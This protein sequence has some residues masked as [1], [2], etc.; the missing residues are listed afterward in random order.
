MAGG[1]LGVSWLVSTVVCAHL[2]RKYAKQADTQ[3][4]LAFD[5]DPLEYA[6]CLYRAHT[7][8]QR[9][10][11]QQY[12]I[13]R[14][15]HEYVRIKLNGLGAYGMKPKVIEYLGQHLQE[16]RRARRRMQ[17]S[18]PLYNL[19]SKT[20]SFEGRIEHVRSLALKAQKDDQQPEKNS[21][22]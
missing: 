16:C 12:K 17:H 7:D 4:L 9:A 6:D 15:Y 14:S 2:S 5:G 3:A 19:L 22:K 1:V 10:H 11:E 20:P 21:K 13:H 18:S 8:E